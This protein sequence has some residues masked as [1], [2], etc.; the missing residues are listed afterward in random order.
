MADE[1]STPLR[2]PALAGIAILSAALGFAGGWVAPLTGL[3]RGATEQVVHDYILD[4]PEVLPQAMERLQAR[5]TASRMAP[6]R[7]IVETPFP[8]AFLGNPQGTVVM[9]EFSDFACGYCRQ[10]VADVEALI[11]QNKDLKVVMR[12]FPILSP[13]SVDAAKMALAAAEQGKFAAFHKAMFAAGRP[14]AQTIEQA[15]KQAGLDLPRARKFAA[16]P[17][18]EAEIGRNHA[19]GE[20]MGFNGTPSWVIGNQAFSG[21]VGKRTLADAVAAARKP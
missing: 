10:S 15:A 7:K 3:T 4:H 6:I 14:S 19:I 16:S 8:G 20:R 11:A 12:E 1:K 17:V 13:A 9:V 2:L 5:E 21:A 18:V